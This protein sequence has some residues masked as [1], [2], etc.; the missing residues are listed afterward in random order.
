VIRDDGTLGWVWSRALPILS[1]T[2]D[3]V[4][5]LG[6]ALNLTARKNAE[7]ALRDSDRRKDQ[8]LRRWPMNCATR[9]RRCAAG[10]RHSSGP[11]R[12]RGI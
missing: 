6:A 1:D 2:G 5:W 3:I 12:Q 4:E 7:D 11:L 9:S 10:W 8:F